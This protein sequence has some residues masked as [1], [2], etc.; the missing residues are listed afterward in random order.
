M[1]NVAVDQRERLRGRA[2]RRPSKSQRSADDG[3]KNA[4]AGEAHPR[5]VEC[6]RVRQDVVQA[7]GRRR[8]C[9][10]KVEEELGARQGARIRAREA[11]ASGFGESLGRA[12]GH[13]GEEYS[14]CGTQAGYREER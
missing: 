12:W 6:P 13:R 2:K 11:R 14:D 5:A 10:V 8:L 4:K 3:R 7:R 1:A 9:T